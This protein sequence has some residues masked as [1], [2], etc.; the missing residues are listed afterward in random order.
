MGTRGEDPAPWRPA[1]REGAA[2]QSAL[3]PSRRQ[4]ALRDHAA[5]DGLRSA[6]HPRNEVRARASTHEGTRELLR[7]MTPLCLAMALAGVGLASACSSAGSAAVRPAE[8]GSG[9]AVLGDA[10]PPA[11]ESSPPSPGSIAREA[12]LDSASSTVVFDRLRGGVW[13]ANGDVGTIT[14]RGHRP[15]SGRPR[16]P[17]RQNITS[18][19][20]SPDFAWIAAVDRTAATVTLVDATTGKVEPRIAL[21]THP[22]AAVWDASDPRWLYVSLEDDGAVAVIDRTLGVLDH[23]VT[24]GRLP[25]GLAV[26]RHAR[27]ARDRPPHR[28][29]RL[30]AAARR[31][32]RTRGP[33]RAAVDIPLASSPS[34]ADDTQPNGT[35]FAQESLAWATDG[36]IGW[37]PHE[38]LADHHPFQF[39]RILFPAV[40]VVDLSMRAEVQTNPNDPS[41]SSRAASCSSARST[42]R[43]RRQHVDRVTAVRRRDAP[44]RARR[45]RRRVR[46]RGPAHVRPDGGDRG[47][48]ACVTCPATTRPAS[49][50]THSGSARSSWLTSRTR[51]SRST[52]RGARSWG[53][54]RSSPG[55]CRSWRRTPIA[56]PLRAG[57]T[58]FFSANS[59][60]NP[61]PTTGNNWM[62][63]G[64]CHLDGFVSTNK[65]FFEA[66]HADDPTAGRARSAT[67]A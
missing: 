7:R 42:S 27:R 15:A 30:G 26:S 40:S 34:S 14:L 10:G 36:N 53:T 33:G 57:V 18:V 62:S 31:R 55:R 59:S 29:R 49:R 6:G 16:G 39:Q 56:P 37:I 43:T 38:L 66:L 50:S 22:R 21:G 5:F 64:G 19:A 52:R 24:V 28:R 65:F 13:T 23:T 45:L 1:T 20:L 58:L 54:C 63:C 67:R 4:S 44:E 12:R 32:L 46:E 17:D 47:R 8:A 35:P 41:A 61:L 60:K 11:L 51:C 25:A 48:P 3:L 9:T 2:G